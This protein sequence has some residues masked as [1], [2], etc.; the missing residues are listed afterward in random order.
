MLKLLYICSNSCYNYIKAEELGDFSVKFE[1]MMTMFKTNE[2]AV[3]GGSETIRMTEV[4]SMIAL[5]VL[6]RAKSKEWTEEEVLETAK[7]HDKMDNFLKVNKLVELEKFDCIKGLDEEL[8][9]RMLKSQ[10][11]KRSRAKSKELTES[12]YVAM[13]VGAI[14]ENALRDTYNKEKGHTGAA[15]GGELTE[16]DFQRLSENQGDLAKAIRNVQSKRSIA[17]YKIDFDETAESYQQLI[18][19][20]ERLKSLR[21]NNT[22]SSLLPIKALLVDIDFDSIKSAEAKALLA[23]INELVNA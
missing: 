10:Q 5:N 20:E 7:D 19:L 16:E 23:K 13:L 6:Q 3:R 4:A 9:E 14:C 12:V 2:V 18:A 17:K 22:S 1:R 15:R 21:T 11:S 8:V